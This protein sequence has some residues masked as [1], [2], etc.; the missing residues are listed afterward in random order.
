MTPVGEGAVPLAGA[1]RRLP[2]AVLRPVRDGNAFE[3]TVEQLATSVRLGVFAGG[4]HLP[5]ERE[6]AE[7]LGVS[8]TTLREAIASLREAVMV[9][10]RR[11]RGGGTVVTYRA[12]APGSQ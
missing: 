2:S 9:E 10:T 3:A 7:T 5:P 1:A 8:R 11:G 6:L 4:E 12:P